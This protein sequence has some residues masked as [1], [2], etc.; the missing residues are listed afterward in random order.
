MWKLKIPAKIKIFMWRAFHHSLPCMNNLVR[1]GVKAPKGCRRCLEGVDSDWHAV[2]E[3]PCARSVWDQSALW[4]K[5]RTFKGIGVDRLCLF[6]TQVL[7]NEELE[8]F[9]TISWAIWTTRNAFIFTNTQRKEKED[10]D[11]A[12]RILEDYTSYKTKLVH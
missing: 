4:Q 1:R 11:L 7:G 10:L 9:T 5:L 8:T 2:W 12:G 3:C 6:A